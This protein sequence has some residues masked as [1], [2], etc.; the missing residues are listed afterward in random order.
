MV[1]F[2]SLFS[3]SVTVSL[4]SEERAILVLYRMVTQKD[5]AVQANTTEHRVAHCVGDGDF[6]GGVK[7]MSSQDEACVVLGG[8]GTFR[9]PR[10]V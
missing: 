2:M 6:S 7:R 9:S 8:N 10:H 1:S 4:A 3:L 5:L